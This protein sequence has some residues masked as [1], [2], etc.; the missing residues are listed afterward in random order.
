MQLALEQRGDVCIV[1]VEEAKFTYPV[2]SPFF[3]EVRRIV[4]QG[5]RK[6]IIDLEAVAYIDSASIGCLIDIH[7]LLADRG[8]SVKLS[9]PK[10]RVHA[11]LSMVLTDKILDI[12]SEE[13]AALAAFAGTAKRSVQL[14]GA[15]GRA[16]NAARSSEGAIGRPRAPTRGEGA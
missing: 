3:T 14:A 8:G 9:G 13:A 15:A 10:P 1:R 16:A 4:E 11:M 12:H 5:A 7:N 2:L 6:L